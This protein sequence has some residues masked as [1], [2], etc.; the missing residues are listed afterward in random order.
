[1][2]LDG[3]YCIKQL[4]DQ[5]YC[6]TF[7]RVWLYKSI[8][9]TNTDI[10]SVKTLWTHWTDYHLLH[11]CNKQSV[12]SICGSLSAY[13]RLN[14]SQRTQNIAANTKSWHRKFIVYIH[15]YMYMLLPPLIKVTTW[16][17]FCLS[18]QYN[19]MQSCKWTISKH[20]D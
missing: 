20:C 13:L 15:V 17:T 6:I 1:M 12:R 7:V 2:L 9:A 4:Y 16:T 11:E 18:F 3:L 19:S 14:E 10:T 5:R 8:V